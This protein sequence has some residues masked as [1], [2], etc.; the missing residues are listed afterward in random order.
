LAW[1]NFI[2][3][4]VLPLIIYWGALNELSSADPPDDFGLG[5]DEA[6]D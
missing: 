3:A 2:I 1:I 6:V 4:L 5:A